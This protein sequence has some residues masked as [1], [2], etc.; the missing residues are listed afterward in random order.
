M[1]RFTRLSSTLLLSLTLLLPACGGKDD[2]GNS[3]ADRLDQARRGKE[4]RAKHGK[5]VADKKVEEPQVP[6]EPITFEVAPLQGDKKIDLGLP[7]RD[8]DNKKVTLKELL[9]WRGVVYYA[10]TDTRDRNNKSASRMLRRIVKRGKNLG[11]PVVVIFAEGSSSDDAARW[12]QARGVPRALVRAAI[13]FDGAFAEATGWQRRSAGLI[14]DQGTVGF[15]FGPTTEWYD[16]LGIEGITDDIYMEAFKLPQEGPAVSDASRQAAA[17]VVSAALAATWE[18][19]AVP[20]DVQAKADAV[21]DATPQGVWVTLFKPG[22]TK[23]SRGFSKAAT[24][25]AAVAQATGAA[26]RV[27]DAEWGASWHGQIDSVLFQVDV[28]GPAYKVPTR[29]VRSLWYMIEPGVDGVIL[30]E[31]DSEG[32]VLPNEAVT[33]GFITPRFRGRDKKLNQWMKVLTRRAG[34]GVRDWRDAKGTEL[35]RFRATSFG[36]TEA[37]GPVVDIERGNVPFEG[38][39]TSDE[40]MASIKLGGQWL[41]DRVGDDGKFEYEYMPNTDKWSSGYNIVRHAGSVYG[42][43]EM[44]NLALEEPA[45]KGDAEQYIAAVDKS[46]GWVFEKLDAP[47]NAKGEGRICLLDERGRCDSGSAALSLLTLLVRPDPSQVPAKYRKN[48]YPDKADEWMEGL[49]LT[50]R[51]MVD[52]RG[53]VFLRY[54]HSVKYDRVKKEPLYYPGEAMLALMRLYEATGDKRWL[55]TARAIGDRQVKSYKKDR[56]QWPDHWVMQ[57][58]PALWRATKKD[59]YADVAYRMAIHS[60]T[61]QYGHIWTPPSLPDYRGAWRRNSDVPRTTRAGSRLEA[62]RAVTEMTWERGLDASILEK[63]LIMGARHLREKQYRPNN[64]YWMS[65]PTPAMGCYPM[66]LVDNSCRIDNNQHALVGMVGAVE[67]ARKAEE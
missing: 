20:A 36:V 15:E 63:S 52:K 33:D 14:D 28:P 51:D 4:D 9:G 32:V 56:F 35:L 54:A 50:L 24:L 23:S 25:G 49:A 18:G 60:A 62:I 1:F 65:N 61:Q 44:Y 2:G 40:I 55:E 5:E 48:I 11:F 29:E 3:I 22:Q 58:L 67:A 31:G 38:D 46:I 10:S 47:K 41:L 26:M 39:P 37:G 57:A 6:T 30:R 19:E 16:R 27:A 34:V 59:D 17:G 45:L 21:S 66:G 42:L 8:L 7:L 64:V 43:L 53:K 13:D 12:F